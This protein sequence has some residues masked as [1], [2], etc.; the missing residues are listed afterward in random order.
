M[1]QRWFR[2]AMIKWV[3]IV[4]VI[5]IGLGVTVWPT[6]S[7]QAAVRRGG[8]IEGVVVSVETGAPLAGVQV[9]LDR[10]THDE[11]APRRTAVTDEAGRFV[12]DRVYPGEYNLVADKTGYLVANYQQQRL[13]RSAP[14]LVE[15]A[16][17]I[18]D[19]QIGLVRGGKVSGQ[20]LTERG[21]PASGLIVKLLRLTQSGDQVSATNLVSQTTDKQGRYVL[22][23]LYPGRYVLRIEQRMK[24]AAG[25]RL[26]FAYYQDAASWP[27]ATPIDIAP[28]EA[29]SDLTIT[30][31][32]K[33]EELA[34][35]GRVVDAQT[36]EP[37]RG[38][39]VSIVEGSNLGMNT[40]TNSDGTYRLEGL[41]VGRY[42]ISV[43]GAGVG[44]GYEW[45]LEDVELAPGGNVIDF[46]LQ[47]A[48][49]ISGTIEYVGAG[50]PPA[51]GDFMV[52]VRVGRNGLG[53]VYNGNDSFGWR[54]LRTGRA[55][56]G[57]GFSSLNYKLAGIWIDDQEVTE[58]AFELRHG[59]K[60]TNVR[61]VLT[62]QSN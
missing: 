57:V 12:F 27:S 3:M 46:E 48:P 37:L 45:R 38:V 23:G 11:L 42:T 1:T 31:V 34:V 60:L 5:L 28:G 9:W 19:V 18:A 6:D 52:W 7:A 13:A 47:P 56:L 50:T 44:D 17:E 55:R 39:L 4:S 40:K 33:S 59:D 51:S 58:K 21:T 25:G 20:V 49:S 16:T 30:F 62:D 41:P 43:Q 8:R 35:T 26:V 61:V 29:V 15:E 53:L 24:Q 36:G 22:Q 54:G 14:L 10:V 2:T 32:P